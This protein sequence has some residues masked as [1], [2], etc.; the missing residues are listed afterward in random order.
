MAQMARRAWACASGRR[1]CPP[2]HGPRRGTRHERA[3]RRPDAWGSR[4]TR[5]NWDN[6]NSGDDWEWDDRRGRYHSHSQTVPVFI[7]IV[8]TA[9]ALAPATVTT[10]AAHSV[11]GSAAHNR[12][13]AR[14]GRASGQ[15]NAVRRLCCADGH[16]GLERD[17]PRVYG[18]RPW[19]RGRPAH[20]RA[21]R[22]ARNVNT[23][24]LA[25]RDT[26][27]AARFQP[28]LV[29][30]DVPGSGAGGLRAGPLHP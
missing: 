20:C 18:Y 8:S 17:A 16:R 14:D 21:G 19:A 30:R 3:A 15:A 26:R 9:A 12:R 25:D 7:S 10:V 22:A 13:Q 2:M 27:T 28:A 24:A 6:R 23:A 11:A 29:L 5:D 4:D 1:R